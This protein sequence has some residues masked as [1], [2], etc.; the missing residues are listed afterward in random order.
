MLGAAKTPVISSTQDLMSVREMK[1][2]LRSE[3]SSP[4]VS[5]MHCKFSNLLLYSAPRKNLSNVI[6]YSS[7]LTSQQDYK[8]PLTP[9]KKQI[10]SYVPQSKIF[11]NL[12]NAISINRIEFPEANEYIRQKKIVTRLKKIKHSSVKITKS[13]VILNIHS[14]KINLIKGRQG[15]A[16]Y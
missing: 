3:Q 9:N 12:N 15:R 13:E 2:I 11:K 8:I 16:I 4:L 1:S 6:S 10:V 7:L 5:M 14:R